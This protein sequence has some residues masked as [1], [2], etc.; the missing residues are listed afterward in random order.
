MRGLIKTNGFFLMPKPYRKSKTPRG[1]FGTYIRFSR[2]MGVKIFDFHNCKT[3][4]LKNIEEEIRNIKYA[5]R[6]GV[7]PKFFKL[8]K[9]IKPV[10]EIRSDDTYFKVYYGI[11]MGHLNGYQKNY[12]GDRELDRAENI[13]AAKGISFSDCHPGNLIYTGK[14]KFKVCDFSA[15]YFR[16]IKP[17][18]KR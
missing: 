9:I 4:T 16:I 12:I 14:T 11:V 18:K 10:K 6:K 5:Y 2:T 8:V 1:A 15:R 13:L 3:V 7:G 17:R